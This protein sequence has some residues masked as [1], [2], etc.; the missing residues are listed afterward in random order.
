MVGCGSKVRLAKSQRT[1]DE[2]QGMARI[3]DQKTKVAT[4]ANGVERI[5]Q[6]KV[7]AQVVGQPEIGTIDVSKDAVN[8]AKASGKVETK[9]R[10]A[11]IVLPESDVAQF[12]KNTE[13]LQAIL[14]DPDLGK[15]VQQK[16]K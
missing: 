12:V 8:E 15:A 7:Q 4:D 16:G 3:V 5:A 6:S 11:Y 2:V 1:P 13:R 14:K 10:T 9:E